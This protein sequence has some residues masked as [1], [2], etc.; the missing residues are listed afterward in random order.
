MLSTYVLENCTAPGTGTTVSLAGAI[1]GRRSFAA[2]FTSGSPVFYFLDDGTQAEWGIGTFTSGTPNTVSRS[3]V[4]SNTATTTSRLNFTGA[5]RIYS[6]L[7]ASNTVWLDAN[8]A[9]TTGMIVNGYDAN[10]FHYRAVQGSYGAGLRNDGTNVYLLPTVSGLQY[11]TWNT[12]RPFYWNLS[13]GAVVIDGT[14][15]GTVL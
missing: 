9:K 7:P 2:V 13:S 1:A 8:L 10:G 14:G 4:I 15:V 3:T 11:G 12:F 6:S 5:T